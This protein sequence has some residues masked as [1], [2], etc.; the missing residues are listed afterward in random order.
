MSELGRRHLLRSL[1]LAGYLIFTAAIVRLSASAFL[2]LG[3]FAHIPTHG[4]LRCG[5][6]LFAL[7]ATYGLVVSTGFSFFRLGGSPTGRIC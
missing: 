2:L 6:S 5:F 4:F 7:S 3:H 1:C